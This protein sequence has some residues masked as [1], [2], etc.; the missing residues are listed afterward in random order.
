MTYDLSKYYMY[1]VCRSRRQIG[2]RE[3]DG[4]MVTLHKYLAYD[5]T[6]WRMRYITLLSVLLITLLY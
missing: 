4:A 5:T 3:W 2:A 1:Q 6:L